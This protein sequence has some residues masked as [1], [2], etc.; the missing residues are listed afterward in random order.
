MFEKKTFFYLDEQSKSFFLCFL[1]FFAKIFSTT[2]FFEKEISVIATAKKSCFLKFFEVFW[3]PLEKSAVKK[4]EKNRFDK[5]SQNYFGDGSLC[6]FN[7]KSNL[8]KN[9]LIYARNVVF[10]QNS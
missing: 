6:N 10:V 3:K 7:S 9:F 8:Q 4:S 5:W 1:F 2:F